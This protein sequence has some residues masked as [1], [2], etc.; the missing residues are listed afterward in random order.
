MYAEKMR[1]VDSILDQGGKYVGFSSSSLEV[2]LLESPHEDAYALYFSE[3]TRKDGAAWTEHTN[4]LFDL[5]K[6]KSH[7]SLL[8]V[9]DMDAQG[10]HLDKP[11]ITH[12]TNAQITTKDVL[13]QQK[14]LADKCIMRYDTGDLDTSFRDVPAQR[15]M[16]KIPC[17]G[18]Q[19]DPDIPHDWICFKCHA[20]VEYSS[21]TKQCTVTAAGLTTTATA[22]SV[23]P[24]ATASVTRD[25]RGGH[26]SS[27]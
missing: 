21:S 16:V 22:S 6:T 11:L 10:H 9:V 4:L 1:F 8:V 18:P 20:P 24:R 27:C 23:R 3:A 5:I 25:S 13:E 2:A 19:C 12:F 15:K 26:C 17:P 7:N 14:L